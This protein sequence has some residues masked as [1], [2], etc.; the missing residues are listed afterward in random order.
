[1]KGSLHNP[2][3]YV[4]ANIS[5]EDEES[6]FAAHEWHLEAM[7]NKMKDGVCFDNG[8]VDS[9]GRLFYAKQMIVHV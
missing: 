7:M 6:R 4:D 2:P 3:A 1:M 8:N 5:A 9:N